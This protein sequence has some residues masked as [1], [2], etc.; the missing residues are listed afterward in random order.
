MKRILLGI[1]ICAI[2]VLSVQA[3]PWAELEESV[4]AREGRILQRRS[5]NNDGDAEEAVTPSKQAKEPNKPG[6]VTIL[7]LIL[8]GKPVKISIYPPS[9]LDTEPYQAAKEV[10]LEAYNDWFK[11]AVN[12]IKS[13]HREREFADVL[14]IL[15]R[16]V[17]IM[18]VDFADSKNEDVWIDFEPTLEKL[19][20][21]CQCSSCLGCE[22]SGRN[23]FS[24]SVTVSADGDYSTLV[25][26][27]GHT[28]GFA[29]AYEAGY[30]KNASKTHRSEQLISFSVMSTE[31]N[32]LTPDD[33]DGL[34]NMIDSR[35]IY[36]K[37]KQYPKDWKKH[38]SPRI[39]K[40][41]NSL[42]RYASGSSVDH[43][44]MGTSAKVLQQMQQ[45]RNLKTPVRNNPQ[46]TIKRNANTGVKTSFKK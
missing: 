14:P 7:P 22:S 44:R 5:V 19:Q 23:D 27:L 46:P 15:K 28:L 18:F 10:V 41:W 26:E 42:L 13:E 29:D 1:L 9:S 33:A 2:C 38:L 30:Q 3:E 43:Y 8:Q 32:E 4:A 6:K 12:V 16:G 11:N 31:N 45:E 35:T 24:I 39:L 20:K 34:I 36:A 21:S 17:K 25:H 40:G 37:K